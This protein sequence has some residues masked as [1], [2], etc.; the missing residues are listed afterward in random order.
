[1]TSVDTTTTLENIQSD[2]KSTENMF[3][4]V[5]LITN[6]ELYENLV[7]YN[8]YKYMIYRKPL[9][10]NVIFPSEYSTNQSLLTTSYMLDIIDTNCVG[11]RYEPQT[12]YSFNTSRYLGSPYID[13]NRNED[14][15]LGNQVEKKCKI[16]EE[17]L[18]TKNMKVKLVSSGI[19]TV[20]F[21]YK[22]NFLAEG[23]NM[24]CIF[25]KE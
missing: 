2:E 4:R 13:Y 11:C 16:F 10:Q 8:W 14:N 18:N 1:M 6:N 9:T 15:K 20:S 17:F 21:C 3:N 12:R 19:N 25:I 22:K 7:N 23:T 5:D 24:E